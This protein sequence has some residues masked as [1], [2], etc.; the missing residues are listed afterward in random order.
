MWPAIFVRLDSLAWLPMP[1]LT[2]IGQALRIL[3]RERS[4]LVRKRLSLILD[5][6]ESLLRTRPERDLSVPLA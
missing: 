3:A 4:R 6:L 2:M 1:V 5:F